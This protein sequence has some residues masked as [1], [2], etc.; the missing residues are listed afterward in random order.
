MVVQGW[1]G[2]ASFI[3]QDRGPQ[4]GLGHTDIQPSTSEPFQLP[5]NHRITNSS[6]PLQFN[7]YNHDLVIFVNGNN[8]WWLTRKVIKFKEVS[9]MRKIS[10]LGFIPQSNSTSGRR[11]TV[12]YWGVSEHLLIP[13][14]FVVEE[15][16]QVVFEH[17]NVLTPVCQCHRAALWWQYCEREGLNTCSALPYLN[18]LNLK[19]VSYRIQ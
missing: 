5:G 8:F 4:G 19:S 10:P 18:T 9:Y 16:W 7:W 6:L 2:A 17:W 14:S 15:H 11:W 1:V 13:S 3:E 12:L